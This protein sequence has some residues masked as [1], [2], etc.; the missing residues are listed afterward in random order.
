MTSTAIFQWSP[1]PTDKPV[2]ASELSRHIDVILVRILPAMNDYSLQ[3]GWFYDHYDNVDQLRAPP[4]L[5]FSIDAV[6]A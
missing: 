6:H 2:E 3:W 5:V 1:P 4:Y